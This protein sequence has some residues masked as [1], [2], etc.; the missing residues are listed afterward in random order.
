MEAYDELGNR[1]VL[2]KYCISRPTNMV[3]SSPTLPSGPPPPPTPLTA[4]DTDDSNEVD[5][6]TNLL[7][8][9]PSSPVSASSA[10]SH[11]SGLR[12][13]TNSGSSRTKPSKRKSSK[14]KGSRGL[15]PPAVDIVPTGDPVVVK[16]RVSTLP[17]DIKL[18]LQASDRVRDLKQRLEVEHEVPIRR[19]TMLYSGRVLNDRTYI[20]HLDIPKGFLIQAIVN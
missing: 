7:F 18:T 19:I 16:I 14:S 9:S 2:P 1:Y 12:R 4:V 6:G 8:D 13:R 17:K 3:G 20:K 15:P 5:S 11:S 10:S